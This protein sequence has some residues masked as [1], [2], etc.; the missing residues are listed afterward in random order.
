MEIEFLGNYR[1]QNQGFCGSVYGWGGVAR[2]Y[3]QETTKTPY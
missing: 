3:E 1:N 2:L